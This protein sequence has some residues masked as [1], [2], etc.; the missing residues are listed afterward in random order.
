ML[1]LDAC[2]RFLS[3]LPI[4][5]LNSPKL[6]PFRLNHNQAIAIEKLKER[7]SK[8]RP[9]WYICLK[10][11]RVGMS[12]LTDALGLCHAVQ[13][14]ND[15]G[16]IVAHL[17]KSVEQLFRVPL[18]LVRGMNSQLSVNIPPPTKERIVVPHGDGL[19]EL[20]IATA[21]SVQ[22][23][24]GAGYYFLH[25]CLRGDSLVFTKH[26][27]LVPISELKVGDVVRTHTGEL[28]K[29]R[30]ISQRPVAKGERVVEVR[31]WFNQ[32]TLTLT[33]DHKVWTRQG[34]KAA[35][36]LCPCDE[37]GTAVRPLTET[38][39]HLT[40]PHKSRKDNRGIKSIQGDIPLDQEF[41]FFCGYYL[42]EGSIGSN[43]AKA[44]GE[45]WAASISFAHHHN[46]VAFAERAA[47][48]VSR[49]SRSFHT[50]L[51]AGGKRAVTNVYGTTLALLIEQEFGRTDQ[52]QI[53]EWIFDAPREFV[54]GLVLG[55]LAGDGS[56]GI[57]R[58][59]GYEAPT[60]AVTSIRPRLVYQLRHLLAALGWGWGGIVFEQ[61]FTDQ[62]A[63]TNRDSWTLTINGLSAIHIRKQLG[64]ECP[65]DTVENLERRQ[66]A[67]KYDIAGGYVWTQVRE[68]KDAV[69]DDVWDIEVDHP[70]HSFETVIGAVAN[71]EAAFYPSGE[72]MLSLL[73]TVPSDPNT[74]VCIESTAYGK[75]GQGEAFYR[76]W[77]RAE[78]GESDYLPIFL[79]W[80]DDP[81]CVRDPREMEGQELDQEEK[82]LTKIFKLNLGQ[83][84]WRRWT[85][86]N[87]CAAD[88]NR[89]H[90]EYPV[91]PE[92]AFISSGNPAFGREEMMLARDSVR[93]PI[94][95][96]Y[97]ERNGAFSENGSG[98]A[99]WSKPQP[100]H[101]Y[102]VGVDAARGVQEGD[103]AAITILDGS[104]NEIVARHAAKVGPRAL[105]QVV[106]NLGR[107]FNRA[108]VCVELTGNL[109]GECL[110]ELRDIH[111]YPNLYRR[112]GKDDK[113][114]NRKQGDRL[115]GF[116]TQY[117]SREQLLVAFRE[118]IRE[119]ELKVRDEQIVSQMEAAQRPAV[120]EHWELTKG[121]DDILIS[122]ML[123]NIACRHYPPP[124]SQGFKVPQEDP[125]DQPK[126]I[127]YKVTGETV[128]EAATE[129]FK[130][131]C[132]KL[133]RY[134]ALKGKP[135]RLE[136]V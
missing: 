100:G 54:K 92:E 80:I 67:L 110:R 33:A 36:E 72:V 120:G 18:N 83:L 51:H 66:R 93:K 20:S 91:T 113:S 38:K 26:G 16:L 96:G 57:A 107:Y 85:L 60:I 55:Y 69:A 46:E 62:R 123:A 98:T 21:G 65:D 10:S 117:R 44:T 25:L 108:L 42:A 116:E 82:E 124:R 126:R 102:Y 59:G 32:Q 84:A 61:G 134:T 86:V 104:T 75:V 121:H 15:S 133:E 70:D 136:G 6:V 74:M 17:D 9:L 52:K 111:R 101:Y 114:A 43:Q 112:K 81:T 34:W 132:R 95:V 5:E 130:Q 29:V 49:F 87:K 22:G 128:A 41:G 47:K 77:K 12:S 35:G 50:K 106:N 105:A 99:F 71:S 2:V 73:N 1:N 14:A 78:S 115:L 131:H 30:F 37:I 90:Q 28:T 127:Q 63:W 68:V 4:R 45:V 27:N 76:E 11:R 58:H 31:T 94:L 56:K 48:A 13:Y 88:I 97:I 3:K 129:A 122:A 89:L 23:G 103:F 135:D 39:T 24:R 40:L 125:A 109:G 8:G 79:S 7:Q 118:S 53:P 119:G 19:S 64:L